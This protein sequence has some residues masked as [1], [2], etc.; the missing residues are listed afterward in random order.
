[1]AKPGIALSVKEHIPLEQGL[2]LLVPLLLNSRGTVKEHIP[3]EQG[4]RLPPLRVHAR[5]R[6]ESKSIF[7]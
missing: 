5:D 6:I 2:R 7:H 4:L 3:L 1:M